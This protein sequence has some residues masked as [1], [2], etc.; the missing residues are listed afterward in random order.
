MFNKMAGSDRLFSY[1]PI[2][3]VEHSL[4]H[5][6]FAGWTFYIIQARIYTKRVQL[7]ALGIRLLIGNYRIRKRES[8]DWV[9]QTEIETPSG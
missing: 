6:I 3:T 1:A 9:S 4:I 2:H 7:T 8:R 5:S